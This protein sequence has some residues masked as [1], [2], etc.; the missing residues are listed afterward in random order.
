MQDTCGI[1]GLTATTSDTTTDSLYWV[2]TTLPSETT[3]ATFTETDSAGNAYLVAIFETIKAST[4]KPLSTST[5]ASLPS[6]AAASATST[7][8]SFG[9]CSNPAI[10]YAYGLDGRT[11]YSFEPANMTQFTHGSSL[12]IATIESFMCD[13]FRDTCHVPDD[14]QAA[15]TAA[16]NAY[17]G[18]AG[19]KAADAWNLALGLVT[20]AQIA[21]AESLSAAAASSLSSVQK[22]ISRA[23]A[24]ELS[25]AAATTITTDGMTITTTKSLSSTTAATTLTATKTATTTASSGD[26][27]S[28]GGGS[29]FGETNAATP[30]PEEGISCS[31]MGLVITVMVGV[32]MF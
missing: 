28:D 1:A 6:P 22:S 18:L 2:Q 29:P 14:T 4:T 31:L 7:V 20:P 30:N 8:Y 13:R 16:F 23:I 21:S 27:S 32:M 25:A 9:S 5:I 17:S 12:D 11:D 15:C 10:I 19:Q 26:G 24:S 3:I